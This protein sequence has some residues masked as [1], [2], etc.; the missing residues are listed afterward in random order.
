VASDPEDD[1]EPAEQLITS[2]VAD[3]QGNLDCG[4]VQLVA[5]SEVPGDE[6]RTDS[7]PSAA[8]SVLRAGA[9]VIGA[10]VGLAAAAGGALVDAA[11]DSSGS[12]SNDR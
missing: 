11:T 9:S 3:E 12:D 4:T 1:E 10:A 7:G 2:C 6:P 5:S 8:G